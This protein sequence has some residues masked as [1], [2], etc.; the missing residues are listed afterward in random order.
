MQV[1]LL[2]CLYAQ[3]TA[4]V[5]Q[6]RDY[7][8]QTINK[9]LTVKGL[10]LKPG[11]RM[12]DA[13]KHFESKGFEKNESFLKLEY[14]GYLLTGEFMGRHNINIYLIPTNKN[15]DIL[16]IVG[17]NFPEVDS[18][19]SLK[20]EYNR[21]KSALSEKYLLSES[22]ESFDSKLIEE[23]TS[24]LLKLNALER[25]EAKFESRFQVTNDEGALMLGYIVLG[26][27]HVKVDYRSK[28]YVSLSYHT[29]DNV[30]EQ[31]TESNDD[32]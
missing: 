2:T 5:L 6:Y 14:G 27:S 22:E 1:F 26:I 29:S 31:L 15:K 20:E 13:L 21:L 30:V 18:F 4:L 7:T 16:G 32:L 3:S 24:D 11:L 23:S 12:K 17:I 8:A 25:N 19:K 9:Y 10:E 28:C